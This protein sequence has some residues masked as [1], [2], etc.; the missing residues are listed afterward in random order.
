MLIG[1]YYDSDHYGGIRFYDNASDPEALR[2]RQ[3]ANVYSVR[4]ALC[5]GS[6]QLNAAGIFL[7]SGFCNSSVAVDQGVLHRD[8]MQPF[9]YD[10]LPPLLQTFNKLVN[11]RTDSPWLRPAYAMSVATVYWSRGLYISQKEQDPLR[12]MLRSGALVSTRRTLRASCARAEAYIS[13]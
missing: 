7:S 5:H 1:L 11:S 13:C 8:N 2:F 12:R 9:P 10:V 6:W 3:R 4:P